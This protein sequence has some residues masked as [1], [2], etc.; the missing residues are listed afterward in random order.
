MA[1]R[2]SFGDSGRKRGFNPLYIIIEVIIIAIGI[3][4]A[5]Q[6][7][8][9][10]DR[11]KEEALEIKYLTEMLEEANLNW[12][13][14]EL[15]QDFR[16]R[17]EEYLIKLMDSRN[18]Q[19][20]I[21]TIRTAMEM[22]TTFRFYSPTNSVYEDLISSGNL[23][24]IESDTIRHMI[25]VDK[26]NSTRAPISEASEREYVENQLVAYFIKRK[27]YSLL[28]MEEDLTEIQ[29]TERQRDQITA[30]LFQDQ[31]FYDHVYA[32]LTRLQQVL[33]FSNPIQWNLRALRIKL[34]EEIARKE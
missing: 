27:V 13:E 20:N 6:V 31:E 4:I 15:D 30:A 2:Y 7:E 22:L 29:S 11:R 28:S 14:L 12:R 26:Q 19:V 18:R 5:F 1:N 8:A 3:Y 33:Y 17:Q 16:R 10:G 25:L 32:R 21:D 24:I 9:W 34:E 23:S